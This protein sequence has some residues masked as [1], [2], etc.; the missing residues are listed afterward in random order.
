MRMNVCSSPSPPSRLTVDRYSR[1]ARLLY[2]GSETLESKNMERIVG[3]PAAMLAALDR[4]YA[5]GVITDLVEY[6]TLRTPRFRQVP[7]TQPA[8]LVVL[9]KTACI[10][11]C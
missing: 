5:S 11:T 3:L 1:I 10:D 9:P 2:L 4:D 7:T 6:V 8:R